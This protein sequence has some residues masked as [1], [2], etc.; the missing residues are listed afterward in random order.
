MFESLFESLFCAKNCT[1]LFGFAFCYF[2]SSYLN[3]LSLNNR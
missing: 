1:L 3:L 2:C